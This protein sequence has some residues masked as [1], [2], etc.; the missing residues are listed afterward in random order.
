MVP[1]SSFSFYTPTLILLLGGHALFDSLVDKS[2]IC[3]IEIAA[4]KMAPDGRY[5][6]Q[7]SVRYAR[8]FESAILRR[9]IEVRLTEH[10]DRSRLD[11]R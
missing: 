3:L 11:A 5:R 9:E 1:F 4:R 10:N 8:H 7:L 6:F 2:R